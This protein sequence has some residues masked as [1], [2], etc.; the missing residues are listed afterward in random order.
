MRTTANSKSYRTKLTDL[1]K[2][3]MAQAQAEADRILKDAEAKAE[4]T[5]QAVQVEI[6]AREHASLQQAQKD[7]DQILQQ[8]VASVNLEAQK[9][10]LASREQLLSEVF[11]L[12]KNELKLA[13]QWP[14]YPDILRHLIDEAIVNL[15]AEEI[16]LRADTQ[17][18]RNLDDAFL[19]HLSKQSSV[20]MKKGGSMKNGVGVIGETPDGH[21]RYLSTLEARLER[22][23]SQLR[24]R[25]YYILVGNK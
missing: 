1:S 2:G 19:A 10:R 9:M 20:R 23:Q 4:S 16:I 21:R 18:L 24:T 11:S 6:E 22:L 12:A 13:F 3:I 14:D 15:D 25:V 5:R 7:A 8:A 17:T